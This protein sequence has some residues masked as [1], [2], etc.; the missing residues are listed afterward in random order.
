MR[1]RPRVLIVDDE[2]ETVVL[3]RACLEEEGIDVVGTASGGAEAVQVAE[4]LS[5]DVVLMDIRMPVVSGIEATRRIKGRDPLVQVI[6]LTFFG[7]ADWT[8]AARET[9]AFCILVKG[10]PPSMITEMIRRANGHKRRA[11]REGL[12]A[13]G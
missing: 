6:L 4:E 1:A 11:E 8:D 7:E 10:C 9:G 13:T 3:L 2:A 12:A 5:P